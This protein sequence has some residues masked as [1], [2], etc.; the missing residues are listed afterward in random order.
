MF[1]R[2]KSIR[3][4]QY[5][6]TE[7]S[8]RVGKTVRKVS[9]YVPKK[10]TA[11]PFDV[12]NREPLRNIVTWKVEALQKQQYSKF[13]CYGKQITA[14]EEKKVH[15]Q[16]LL[17]LL[18]PERRKKVL[19][20]FLRT[21][22]VNS[23]AMEGGTIS[24]D[25]AKA[26]DEK[27]KVRILGV[28]QLDIPLYHQLQSAYQKLKILQLRYPRQI[29]ELHKLIYQG[30]YPFAGQFRTKKVTFGDVQG[31][32]LTV[33][34]KSIRK[35]YQHAIKKYHHSK[36]TI[37]DFER[38]VLFHVDFQSVHGFEDGNSRLGR[39]IMMNQFLQQGYPP[40][41]IRG[42]QSTAYRRALVRAINEQDTTPLLKL[43]YQA[44]MRTWAKFWKP[45]LEE[46]L[47]TTPRS[48]L[49]ASAQERSRTSVSES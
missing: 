11:L 19:D 5:L 9:F 29:Q 33:D 18:S 15:F 28:H 7:H 45:I 10:G 39:L 23:M 6:Y 36:G 21:F 43:M 25:V 40:L 37:Y 4:Q 48:A 8:F 14:I 17:G 41:L 24:Y 44:Y 38:I 46:A 49:K 27:K 26:L 1:I 12:V 30:I 42:S 35:S 3:G 31:L 22:L 34:P 47:Q 20:E 16:V 13:F 2:H 32:A